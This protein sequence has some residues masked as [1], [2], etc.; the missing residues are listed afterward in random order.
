MREELF[1]NAGSYSSAFIKMRVHCT[2]DLSNIANVKIQ[3][4]ATYFHEYIHFLQDITT[5]YGLMNI[6]NIV[7]YI[8]T[9][10]NEAIND[11]MSDFK[12]PFNPQS[13]TFHDVKANWELKN[14]YVGGG[15]NFNDV[16]KVNSICKCVNPVQTSKGFIYPEKLVLC[17]DDSKGNKHQ[18]VIGAHCIMESMAYLMEQQLYPGTLLAPNKLPYES[19][20][21]I[22]DFIYPLFSINP[23]NI[24][25]LCDACLMLFNPG[26]FLYE[27]IMEMAN[28]NYLPS[29][30]EDVY[31]YV[32]SR[33][34]FEYNGLNNIQDLFISISSASTQ[35]FKDYFTTT[36][37]KDNNLWIECVF[38]RAKKL[39]ISQPYFMLD[40]VRNGVL[41]NNRIISNSVYQNLIEDL[42]TPIIINDNFELFFIS[43]LGSNFDLRNEY[44]WVVNQVYKIYRDG[45]NSGTFKCEMIAWCDAKAAKLGMQK[46]TTYDC[47][48][49]PW[50]RAIESQPN[51]CVFSRLWYTWG[52]KDEN[53]IQ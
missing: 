42:G 51:E 47:R 50:V 43:P 32:N 5:T 41:V 36:T 27:I 3:T 6:S 9:A 25:A 39:R 34:S 1:T 11:G 49:S 4:E 10:N 52:M 20:V 12:V 16:A 38:E 31:I 7:D 30:P 28:T 53:P 23:L 35:Q 17:F 14:I 26:A 21:I 8:K 15:N 48:N 19:I 40:L 18:T 24:I 33:V 22:I 29:K 13:S 44:L 46:F 45:L 2:E 37:F